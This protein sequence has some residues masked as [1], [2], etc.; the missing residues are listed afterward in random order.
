MSADQF[1]LLAT[2]PIKPGCEDEY[3]ALVN[4]VNDEMRR[5]PTF[6]NSVLHRSA[7]DPGLFMLHETWRDREDFFSVQMNR[8]YRARYEAR[9]PDLL[10]APREMK[11]FVPLRVDYVGPT[12][13]D[14]GSAGEQDDKAFEPGPVAVLERFYE[15]EGDYMNAGG[16]AGGASFKALAA[17]L[18]P[19]VVLHQ[20][21]DLPWG[22]ESHGHAG[23]EDWAR[24]MSEA[25]DQLEVKDRQLFCV[26][27]TVVAVCR[28]VTRA[29]STGEI[30][31]APMAQVVTVRGDRIIAFRPFYWNVPEYQAI[32]QPA[33][34]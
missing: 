22:G 10:R 23:Y 7:E 19:D 30:L 25:F 3:L 15:A 1:V 32:V 29:R 20:S 31:D 6:V 8:P 28:L 12:T 26:G 4:T 14:G 11:V 33:H 27:D 5:E 18:D 17:T 34:D 9:L 24:R 21:P 2:V 16:A 13:A